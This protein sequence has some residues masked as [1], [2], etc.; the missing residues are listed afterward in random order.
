M[1]TLG[2]ALTLAL[3]A[4]TFIVACGD[5]DETGLDDEIEDAAGDAAAALDDAWAN[6]ETD[7]E[8]LVDEIQSAGDPEAKQELLDRC[9]DVLEELRES[10]SDRAGE[11]EAMCDRIRDT[12]VDDNDAWDEVEQEIEELLPT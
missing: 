3:A 7:G 1:Q 11:V 8:R 2:R 10:D 12:D 9:R 4:V 6:L 5:S